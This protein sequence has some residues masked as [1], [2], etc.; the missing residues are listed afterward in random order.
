MFGS[1]YPVKFKQNRLQQNGSLQWC[2]SVPGRKCWCCSNKDRQVKKHQG[3]AIIIRKTL[4]DGGV[5]V[6][7][8]VGDNDG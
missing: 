7:I 3:A 6:N 8:E 5:A 4:V 2:E 1:G